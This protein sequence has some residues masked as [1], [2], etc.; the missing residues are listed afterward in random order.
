MHDAPLLLCGNVCRPVEI[1]KDV[2]CTKKI[3]C[4]DWTT[5]LWTSLFHTCLFHTCLFHTC[6]FTLVYFTLVY[7]TLDA[8]YKAKLSTRWADERS[9]EARSR[10]GAANIQDQLWTYQRTYYFIVC[11]LWSVMLSNIKYSVTSSPSQSHW[12]HCPN[13]WI[14]TPIDTEQEY[15]ERQTSVCGVTYNHSVQPKVI[16]VVSNGC[17]GVFHWDQRLQFHVNVTLDCNLWWN[18]ALTTTLLFRSLWTL[19]WFQLSW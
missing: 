15:W 3:P 8:T 16:V 14:L 18:C 13:T 1:K 19:L 17:I 9:H 6:L 12:N 10:H 4:I 11:Y 7:F 2:A 5:L